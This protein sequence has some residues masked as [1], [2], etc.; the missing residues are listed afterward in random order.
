MATWNSEKNKK[1]FET[2][3][4]YSAEE[5][6]A[7]QEVMY[8][9]Y[10]SSLC[11]EVETMIQMVETG[12]LPACA[13]DLEKYKGFEKLGGNRKARGGQRVKAF[14]GFSEA[15]QAPLSCFHRLEAIYEAILEQLEKLKSGFEKKPHSSLAAEASYLCDSIKP[16]ML[17]LRAAVDKAEGAPRRK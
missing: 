9:N 11:C 10:I 15:S 14:R 13:K 2:L 4:I 6:E 17:A 1:L 5:T 7:R 12:F 16:Q 8:E 3:K